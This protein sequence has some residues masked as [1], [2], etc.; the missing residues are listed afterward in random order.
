SF[1]DA[2]YLDSFDIVTV[3]ADLEEVFDVKISGAS[4]LPENFQSIASIVNL[5]E[6]SKNAS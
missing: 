1:M 5:V 6:N 3:V 2:G 4:I